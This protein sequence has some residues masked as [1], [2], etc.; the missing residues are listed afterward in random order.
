PIQPMVSAGLFHSCG[1]TSSGAAYCWGYNGN[2][3]LGNGTTVDSSVPV[4]VAD[5]HLF[6]SIG[7]D[8]YHTCAIEGGTGAPYC[9]G[10]GGGGVTPTLIPGAANF[11]SIAAGFNHTCALRADGTVFC[12]GSN[13]GG[14][15]GNGTTT[16]TSVP[17]QVLTSV[18]F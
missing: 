13:G 8:G 18:K 17:T 6:I 9:W 3:Q 7:A 16:A 12:W 10:N 4:A 15:L 11:V 2:A 5:G 1:L 14:E